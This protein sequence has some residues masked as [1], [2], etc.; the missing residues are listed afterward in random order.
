[1]TRLVGS[2]YR[3]AFYGLK[4]GKDINGKEY[5]YK[6]PAATRLA[7]ISSRLLTQYTD[8]YGK[9]TV[10]NIAPSD[11]KDELKK[12][13]DYCYLQIVAV[14]PYFPPQQLDLRKSNWEKHFNSRRFYFLT[15]FT[16]SGQKQAVSLADQYTKKTLLEVEKS[17]PYVKDR[18][19]VIKKDEELVSPIMTALN[20]VTG[21][22]EALMKEKNAQPPNVKTLQLTLQGSVLVTVNSG[23]LE[24][25]KTFLKKE[26]KNK[27]LKNEDDD[28]R[29][30]KEA[31]ISFGNL[32]FDVLE[33][34]KKVAPE[35]KEFQRELEIGYHKITIELET[36]LK[37]TFP[38]V[39]LP[40]AETPNDQK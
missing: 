39:A 27:E 22:C 6:E 14:E 35:Q 38:R 30:L 16:K 25:A 2:F 31:L 17:F 23:L 8:K 1:M 37:T 34:N 4:W 24:I 26:D 9:D 18:L 7:D 40:D 21:R 13:N 20:V 29:K 15:P 19:F 12:S 11:L 32:A 28:I 3:V 36:Y 10:K 33:L 5:I